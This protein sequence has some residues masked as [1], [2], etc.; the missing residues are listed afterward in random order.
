[1]ALVQ[2]LNTV[3]DKHPRPCE[4]GCPKIKKAWDVWVPE[5]ARGGQ[6]VWEHYGEDVH[7]PHYHALLTQVVLP[8]VPGLVL[9]GETAIKRGSLVVLDFGFDVFCHVAD[10]W[11]QRE[12]CLHGFYGA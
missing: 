2:I 4:V 5:E 10:S 3:G 11:R 8:T 6:Q 12:W 9:V 7:S 1:M